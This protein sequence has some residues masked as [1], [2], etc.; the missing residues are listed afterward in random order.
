MKVIYNIGILIYRAVAYLISPFSNKVRL[1]FRGQK[2]WYQ[3]L[4]DN[5][6]SGEKYIWIH[7][8]SLGEF[9][10]GRPVIEEIKKS[11]P[12]YKIA[13]TFFSPSGYEVRKNYEHAD[14]ICYLPA[15]T[16][17]NA[18]RLIRLINPE[19]AIF[20]KY[21]FWNNFIS[22][23][24]RRQIK[25]YLISGIFR[26]EQ[27][28]FKW[29]GSFF[30]S[31][32][33]KFSRIF[34]QDQN[35]LALLKGIGLS[36]C[37]LAG[38]TRFDRVMQITGNARTIHALEKFKGNE[39]LFLAG[40][41]WKQDEEIIAAYI[42]THPD[43]MK[44]VFAPHEP[45]AGNIERLEKLFT[46]KCIR[47][48]QVIE[49][50][51]DARVLIID[52]VGMLS[53]AYRYACIAAVGGGFGKGIHNILEPACWGIPVLFGPN[54]NK[55]READDL[56]RY[57]GGESFRNYDEFEEVIERWLKNE[58][59]YK[60]AALSAGK[61]VKENTGATHKIMQSILQKDI[62]KLHS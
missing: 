62:N 22:E 56:I 48:S 52:N 54:H 20:V 8:A 14:V 32:L 61:Y 31:I 13:L 18:E 4:K 9:E 16:P 2:E 40:S 24:D 5:I 49:E 59:L 60:K 19:M 51:Y 42:N 7:C 15:D 23:L 11:A 3:T 57:G 43:V 41:S 10:Q 45:T 27:L 6:V 46:I 53:S 17:G 28:F 37:S 12:Q 21:E 25:I 50:S 47:F 34:V 38:D 29:Y 55:F 58:E 30:R 33:Q 39:K 35:S 1:W 44:W 26:K 36:S